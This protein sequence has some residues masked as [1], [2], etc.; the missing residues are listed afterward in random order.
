MAMTDVNTVQWDLSDLLDGFGAGEAAVEA[1]LARAEALAD[2]LAQARGQVASFDGPRLEAYMRTTA[3][4]EDLLARASSYAGLRFS[5]DTIDPAN[6]A[7]L[8]KVEER[9]TA[10]A[11]RLLFF[12]L[13]WVALDDDKAEAL[14]A[15]PGLDFCRH[16]LRWARA[17]KPY[18]LSEA[19]EKILVE[20]SVSGRSA[21]DRLFDEQT[22]AIEVVL[23]EGTVP[24]DV[25]LSGLRD[26][27]RDT[28][29]A[30]AQAVTDALAPG[31]RTRAFIFNTLLN[32]KA[33]DDRLRGHGHWLQ[34]RNLD[35]EATDESVEALVESVR[36]RYD[37]PQRWYAL[38]ARIL[39]LDKLADYDRMAAV[40]TDNEEVA[41]DDARRIVLECYESFSPD[42]ANEALKFFENGW[43]DAPPKPGKRGGAF[44][45]YTSPNVHPFVLLNYTNRRDDVQTLA[46]ELGHALHATLAKGQGIFH[47]TTPL[48]VAETASVFGETVVF[49]RLLEEATTP[50]SRLSLLAA[51]I[52]DNI[53]TVFRQTAMNRFEHGVHTAR[54][55]EGELSVERFGEIWYE[56]QHDMLGEA[57]EITD[58][59][60]SWWS[61]IPHFIGSPGYVYAYS[62]GQLLALSVYRQ[63]QEQG[64]DFVPRY[65]H[66]LAS[67]GSMA[68]ED[69]GRIVGCDLAD[70]SFWDGGL[71]LVEQQLDAAETAA[72]EAGRLS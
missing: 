30:T 53:A 15:H 13:E 46:H 12:G 35:N 20:K 26:A 25:A 44:C 9:G 58:N 69:L 6:G 48:T 70:N 71:Q 33:I 10:I 50:E 56:T 7:L 19:E 22:S 11:T 5:T 43:I 3:E 24:L 34:S 8:A 39:G 55:T 2:E 42:M 64:S 40:T 65:L 52:E 41:W 72:W 63:Y 18:L 68:P 60:R 57:V 31:L 29:A 37:I 21:W 49:N 66:M 1:Q 28:R 38:K 36:K 32:D 27:D 61:Y 51:N 4:L 23:P 17:R 16:D 14:L 59:Y 67:G 45:A 47:Q 62:Y 54:R